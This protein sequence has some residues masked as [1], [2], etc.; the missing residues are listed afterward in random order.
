MRKLIAKFVRWCFKSEETP[1]YP[2]DAPIRVGLNGEPDVRIAIWTAINGR[3]LE[4]SKTGLY[5]HQTHNTIYRTM[6]VPEGENLSDV[7][8]MMLLAEGL[9]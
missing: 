5:S 6:I 9:K 8:T 3:V 7:V 1:C 2:V 4:L